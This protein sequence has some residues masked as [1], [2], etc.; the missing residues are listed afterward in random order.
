MRHFA[1]WRGPCAALA[2]AAALLAQASRDVTAHKPITSRYDYS[3]DIFPILRDHCAA[4]HATGGSAPMSLM[5]YTEAVP[6]AEAIREELTA[7]RMPPWPVEPLSPAVRGAHPI[8][9]KE[10]DEIVTWASGGTPAGDLNAKLPDIVVSPQWALGPPDATI[11]MSAPHTVVPGTIDEICE[12][13]LP[14][15][16]AEPR[17]VK[18]ADLLPGTFSIVRDAVITIENGPVLALW[19]PGSTPAAAPEGAAFRLPPGAAIHLQLHYKKHFDQE[20]RAISDRSTVGLYFANAASSHA[21]ESVRVDSLFLML[22]DHARVLALRPMLDVPYELLTVDAV[23]PEGERT[24][25]LVLRDAWPQWFRRYWLEEPV[26]IAVGSRIEVRATPF[27]ARADEPRVPA[28]FSRH[29]A[30]DYVKP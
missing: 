1:E 14:T 24:S 17:W 30:L 5:T 18:A 7:G 23:A 21:I 29:I 25:L 3:H 2:C 22:P 15:S 20:Q 8:R 11:A 28:R 4:C 9:A 16:F 27:P 6:W 10:I 26:E 13:S 19:Q 12:L